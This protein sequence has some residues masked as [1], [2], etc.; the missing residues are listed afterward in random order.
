M[1]IKLFGKSLFE[2][3]KSTGQFIYN[4]AVDSLAKS[5]YLIDFYR[6][7]GS[8]MNEGWAT[9]VT[10]YIITS[11]GGDGM[12]AVPVKKGKKKT[13]KPVEKI[14]ITPK[15][16]YELKMLNDISF[17]MKADPKYVD[18]QIETLKDKLGMIKT[19]EFDMNRGTIEIGSIL[20]RIE[21]RK[22]YPEF[23]EYFDEFPYTTTPKISEMIKVHDHLKLGEVSQFIADMPKDA[24]QV[25]KDYTDKT[26]KL[27]DKNPVFYII[28]DKD[29]FKKSE[30]RRDPILLAQSPFGHFWQI[31]GAWDEEMLIIDEL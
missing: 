14:K 28:A 29:D 12:V 20:S 6:D 3:K 24:I 18:E 1:E 7:T 15:G 27:C 21:N 10:D 17:K 8:S 9:P 26:K 19:K 25:M 30:K 11:S 2:A 5:E 16:V 31:L 4:N 13:P 23:K 22:K